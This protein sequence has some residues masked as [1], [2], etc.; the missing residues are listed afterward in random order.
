[1]GSGVTRRTGSKK[2]VGFGARAR[3]CV[4]AFF[5]SIYR[6]SQ[7]S[8]E[9]T[10]VVAALRASKSI[11]FYPGPANVCMCTCDCYEGRKAEQITRTTTQMSCPTTH[12]RDS[13]YACQHHTAEEQ[14][15]SA[16]RLCFPVFLTEQR[17]A[18]PPVQPPVLVVPDHASVVD[19]RDLLAVPQ[20]VS[21]LLL[22]LGVYDLEAALVKNL[23]TDPEEGHGGDSEGQNNRASTKPQQQP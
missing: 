2:R 22:R 7:L 15:M 21:V 4:F 8:N 16:S 1:M 9:P 3:A 6:V 10:P 5:N 12:E 23:T 19:E 20:H 17:R 11:T 13:T 18:K 14:I